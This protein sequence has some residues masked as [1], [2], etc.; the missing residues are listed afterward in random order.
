MIDRIV[1][2]SEG[3]ARLSIRLD[4]LVIEPEGG[5]TVTTP[6]SELAALVVTHPRV[7]LTQSVISRISMAG[8]AVVFCD[9]KYQP[10]A[11]TLP[12][13]AHFVQTERYSRQAQLSAPAR[14]RLWQ[15][16]VRAKI[17]AQSRALLELHGSDE[18]LSN[19]AQRVRS[20][21]PDNIE[22]QAARRYWPLLFQNPRFRRGSE[23]PDQNTH[24]NYG[25]ALLRA[26]VA[27]ALCA[28]GLHPSFGLQ[29]HNRYDSFCLASDFMEP[30]R[31]LVDK[32]VAQWVREHDP[33]EPL[34][35]RTKQVLLSVLADR[36]EAE[37]EERSL[38]DL[39]A[40]A[41]A[42]LVRVILGQDS[43]LQIPEV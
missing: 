19:M 8:G 38:F 25:Y 5:T 41:G 6:V 14:K 23:G 21:D 27:R 2:V 32:K 26:A 30:F 22:G 29:H 39:L 20:G 11:M 15:Q 35:R 4:Q 9:D 33:A 40:R 31:P 36:Y 16:I 24:L 34:D 18:G 3:P 28:N 13:Q 37:G 43:I 7:Q 1:E 42:S 17:R 10:A 12:L